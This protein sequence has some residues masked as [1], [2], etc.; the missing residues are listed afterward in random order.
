VHRIRDAHPLLDSF[1]AP[2]T[3]PAS[4][5]RIG[6]LRGPHNLTARQEQAVS[7]AFLLGYF[8][9]PRRVQLKDVANALGV[10]RAT[11]ME[12]LRRGMRKLVSRHRTRIGVVRA[13]SS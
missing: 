3:A 1:A 7:T 6:A 4:L 12:N 11:A 13:T 2:G 8:D 5:V 9:F 10:G